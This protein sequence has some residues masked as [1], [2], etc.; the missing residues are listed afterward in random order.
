M[1]D[2]GPQDLPGRLGRVL[3]LGMH[4]RL[5]SLLQCNVPKM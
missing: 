3:A 4:G 1:L 2:E 5:D